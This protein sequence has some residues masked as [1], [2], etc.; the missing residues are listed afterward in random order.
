MIDDIRIAASLRSHR[1]IK[2]LHRRLGAEGVLALIYLWIGAAVSKP[3]G[4]LVSWDVEDIALEAE[5]LGDPQEFV[6]AL[7]DLHLLER[8]HEGNFKLHNWAK[9]QA[10]VVGAD[11]RSW[12][13]QHAAAARWGKQTAC[14]E[15][16]PSM[17]DAMPEHESRNAPFLPLP[18]HKDN[19][20]SS[21]EVAVDPDVYIT[22]K[23]KKLSGQILIDFE[24]FWGAFCYRRGKAE[25]ADA[26]LTVYSSDNIGDI[27]AGAE[28]EAQRRQALISKGGTPKMAQGWLSGR[29]WEDQEGSLTSSGKDCSVCR[30]N[31]GEPCRN[32]IRPE[33]D[34]ITCDSFRPVEVQA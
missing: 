26:F 16:A 2:K 33:F 13:A 25:A 27:V 21:D 14:N 12:K 9:H 18:I 34:P 32:L 31:Q 17:L 22:K 6:E 23:G 29:R 24:M 8:D 3:D 7:V 20:A 11:A 10:W 15:H 5:W 1:K 4:R 19:S 30:Y 28:R